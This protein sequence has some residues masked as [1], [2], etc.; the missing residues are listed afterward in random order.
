MCFQLLFTRA[1]SW[2]VGNH[3]DSPICAK[4]PKLHP[5]QIIQVKGDL[6]QVASTE[7]GLD[8]GTLCSQG[9]DLTPDKLDAHLAFNDWL[10]REAKSIEMCWLDVCPQNTWGVLK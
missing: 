4:G 2:I 8:C 3:R 7:H 6:V 5:A 9:L 1:S 10:Q